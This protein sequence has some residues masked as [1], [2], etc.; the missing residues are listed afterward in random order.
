VTNTLSDSDRELVER[1]TR[2]V[3]LVDAALA[4]ATPEDLDRRHGSDWSA[5]MVVHHLADSETNSYLRLRRL[6]VEPA[7]TLIQGYDEAA[8]AADPVLG[9]ETL[10]IEQSL[11]VFRA[12]RAATSVLLL[13]I[14]PSDME[15]EGT[16]T[17]SG[18]YSL[19]LWLTLYAEHAEQ[20]A[21][22]IV[23]A[24]EITS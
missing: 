13:R 6:L 17:E 11:A 15:R 3:A 23:R 9:Y 2:G 1:Y 4:G 24:R 14:T 16:H 8:W 7:P 22:Q 10:P 12:V 5:R 20:H 18:S 19:R 21:S